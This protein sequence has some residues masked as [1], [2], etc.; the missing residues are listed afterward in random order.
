VSDGI[1]RRAMLASL[2]ACVFASAPPAK[3]A[4]P[5]PRVGEFFRFLDPVTENPVVRLTS[6]ASNSFLPAPTNRFI[7]IKDRFLLFSSD[8]A[9]TLAPFQVDLHSGILTQLANPRR[10][11]PESLTLN[12]KRTALY[13]VDDGSL[14]EITLQN[15]KSRVLTDNVSCFCEL[16]AEDA[17]F[18]LVRNGN[19]E[20]LGSGSAPLARDVE[21]FCL[22]RPGG[23]GCLFMRRAAE[24]GREFWYVPLSSA[25]SATPILL[26]K[27][28]VSNPVWTPD[29]QAVLFLREIVRPN[30]VVTSEIRSVS[31]DRAGERCLA[32]T[33]QFAA[34]SPNSDASVFVGASRSKAQP[35]LLL[36]L[37]SA[38]RELTLCEHRASHPAAV[39]PV[40][41]PDSKRVYFQS[42]HEGKSALYSVNVELLVEPTPGAES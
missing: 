23:L 12:S 37:A 19:L 16:G 36:L 20:R 10:L 17:G 14:Q 15:R 7:S 34:F 40:F 27:G 2:P 11:A 21:S 28:K 29:G 30:G 31:P 5:L 3:K 18:V 24:G 32:P 4:K 13:L 42:D 41:S 38:Q 1:T 26:T 9:G 22:A 39:S 35:T 25:D 6:L 33:S 8:R